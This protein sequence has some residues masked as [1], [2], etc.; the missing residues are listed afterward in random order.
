MSSHICKAMG[1]GMPFAKFEELCIL[2]K[3]ADGVGESLYEAFGKLTDADLTIEDKFT[4]ALLYSGGIR[5]SPIF[6]PRILLANGEI[7]RAT[8]LYE[9]VSPCDG[10]TDIIF[11][12]NLTYRTKWYRWDDDL[13]YAFDRHTPK[14]E[15]EFIPE[16]FTC[17]TK[18]GH[19]PFTNNIM[20]LNGNP[21]NWDHY[22]SLN[23]RTD[24]APEVPSE[25]RW[26]LTQHGILLDEGVNQLRPLIAQW[27]D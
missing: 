3:H 19:Y 11:F 14:T 23:K 18:F 9:M 27:W 2:P 17:Y 21:L 25:I 12:P 8:E 4:R 5:P 15:D 1:Y 10:A 24:W 7:G 16:I 22:I 20:D 26:Y 6:E 13:D